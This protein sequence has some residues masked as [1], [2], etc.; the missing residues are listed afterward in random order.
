MKRLCIYLTYN[1]EN[2]VQPYV[3]YMLSALRTHVE[4]LCVVCNYPTILAGE[5]YVFPYVD[6]V[7]YRE[8]KGFDGGAYKDALCSLLGWKKVSQYDELL[9]V[10]DSFFGPVND[11][12]NCFDQMA[13]VDCDFW[14]I[15]R[16]PHGK[17]VTIDYDYRPHVQSYFLVFRK[18]VLRS[19]AFRDYFED[20]NYAKTFAEGVCVFEIGINEYLEKNGFYGTSLADVLGFELEDG[21][22][23]YHFHSLEMIRDKGMPFLKKKSLLIRNFGF[24]N[25]LNA[26]KYIESKKKYPTEWIWESLDSQFRTATDTLEQFYDRFN[27]IYIY[28]A[29]V[30]G[31]NLDLY[32]K[33]K[34]WRHEGILVT[35]R[36]S[37]DI[38]CFTLEEALIDNDTGIIIS[39]LKPDISS[40]I[41]E[42]IG[43]KCRKEQL[44]LISDC[45][46]IEITC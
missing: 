45:K 2:I 3:G 29:G 18:N 11:L 30:C 19:S 23:L 35:D 46:A 39:I 13:E 34:D 32:F 43:D 9:L 5:E 33:H 37:Q 21:K 27:R 1:K 15:A 24:E 16:N 44:F 17:Y 20:L 41:V 8:N 28:G 10:N 7:F 6:E 14:G 38:E 40:E 42:Y 31:K 12:E 22:I 4:T 25:V 26:I 36:T